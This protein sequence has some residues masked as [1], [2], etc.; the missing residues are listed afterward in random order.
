VSEQSIQTPTAEV[1]D[2]LVAEDVTVTFPLRRGRRKLKVNALRG[3]TIGL[4]RGETLGLVGES[5]SGK[6]TF[7]RALLHLVDSEGRIVLDGVETGELSRRQFR[8][9]RSKVQMVFQDPYSS[10]D[11]SMRVG[12]SI[13]EPLIEHTSLNRVDREAR[14]AELLGKVG[15]PASAAD[16]Y[17]DEFSGG[18]RQRIAIARAIAVAPDLLVCDEAVSALDVSTQNQIL[19]LLRDLREDSGLSYV[20]ISHDLAVVRH[21]SDRVVVMYLGQVV[22]EGPT[23]RVYESFAHPYTRSLLAAVPI[24]DPVLQRGRDRGA[25]PGDLPDPTDPPT[26]CAFHAR[27]A[28][29]MPICA[30]VDPEPTPVDGGGSVRCHL[31]TTGPE[32][33]GRSLLGITPVR[34]LQAETAV[35]P[36][37]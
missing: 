1:E 29:A 26:G 5:G 21:I 25:A 12:D 22:E 9:L 6:S 33:G 15:L 2:L 7:A 14:V 31:Q 3:V 37:A 16:R 20:F 23:E 10:L 11:P 27:C 8:E 34:T 30:E 17:P 32:L 4:R 35:P 13:A 18:Q 19:G 28:Y 36:V 24:P